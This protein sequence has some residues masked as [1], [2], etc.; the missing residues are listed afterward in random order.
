MVEGAYRRTEAHVHPEDA[1]LTVKQVT[2]ARAVTGLPTLFAAIRFGGYDPYLVRQC[3]ERIEDALA[4]GSDEAFDE[5]ERILVEAE[6]RDYPFPGDGDL[7]GSAGTMFAKLGR[8]EVACR[9]FAQSLVTGG[10]SAPLHYNIA[11]CQLHLESPD[12]AREHLHAALAAD[13]AFAPAVDLLALVSEE[14][15]RHDDTGR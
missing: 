13:P 8:Y 12:G 10:P 4:G 3:I 5:C 14:I 9:F 1:Y 15:T 6:R 2:D 11:L 7:A